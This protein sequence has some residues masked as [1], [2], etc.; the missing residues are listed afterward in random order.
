M[1][2][3][4]VRFLLTTRYVFEYASLEATWGGSG[5]SDNVAW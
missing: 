3:C 2:V 5:R 1:I 4:S